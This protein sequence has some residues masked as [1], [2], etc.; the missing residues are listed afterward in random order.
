MLIRYRYDRILVMDAGNVAELD[1]P[2]NLYDQG[3]I[4]R[5]MCD[6][7]GIRRE[8]FFDS[9]EARFAAESPEIERTKSAA[10]LGR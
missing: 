9:E 10:E 4:F 7:S 6:R 2:I 3:G 1:S 5:S 8:D